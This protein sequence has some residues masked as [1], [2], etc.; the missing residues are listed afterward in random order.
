MYGVSPQLVISCYENMRYFH[1][2]LALVNFLLNL[3]FL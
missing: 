3:L 1:V 2:G